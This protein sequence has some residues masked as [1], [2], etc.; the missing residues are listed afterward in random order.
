MG[1]IMKIYM[2]FL[3]GGYTI[4]WTLFSIHDTSPSF[5]FGCHFFFFFEFG[6][7][8]FLSFCLFLVDKMLHLGS[9]ETWCFWLQP[10][11]LLHTMK[12][13]YMMLKILV[14]IDWSLDVHKIMIG[15]NGIG[16]GSDDF[17]VIQNLVW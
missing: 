1:L 14:V 3:A 2:V 10:L 4:N 9:H 5:S 16:V 15:L 12:H 7:C 8:I 6:D 17:S 11:K 13:A